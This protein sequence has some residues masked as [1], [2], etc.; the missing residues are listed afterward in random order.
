MDSKKGRRHFTEYKEDPTTDILRLLIIPEM[1]EYR[2]L[3]NCT[4]KLAN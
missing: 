2:H 3:Q 4:E 1:S